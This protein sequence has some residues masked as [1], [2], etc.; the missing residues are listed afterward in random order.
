MLRSIDWPWH[1]RL[2]IDMQRS[3]DWHWHWRL[4]IDMQRSIDWPWHGRLVIDMQ[5]SIDWPRH[6]R[7][8]RDRCGFDCRL[9]IWHL[10]PR[11]HVICFV[12]H[13]YHR[14]FKLHSCVVDIYQLVPESDSIFHL[15]H[16]EVIS[17]TMATAT[18]QHNATDVTECAFMCHMAEACSYFGFYPYHYDE[19][20]CV[21]NPQV[22]LL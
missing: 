22:T 4:G 8:G 7:L 3:I 1:G 21:I 16:P 6:G 14:C 17:V 2:G 19:I 5:R 13:N 12:F 15:L 20:N 11:K 9:D 18:E 10:I